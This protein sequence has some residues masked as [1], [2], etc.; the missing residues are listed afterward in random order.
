MARIAYYR[1]WRPQNFD[2]VVAQEQV[3]FP[4][5]QS[6]VKG[7]VGHAYLFTGTR[8]TGKT[9]LA[10]IYAKAVNC[11]DI[12]NGNPCN[13]CA[14]C[15]AINDG[16]L[17]DVVE[18]DA[19]SHNSVDNIRRMADEVLFAPVTARYKVYIIDEAHMLSGG[20]FNALLKTLEEPPAHAIFIL[21][22]TEPH[23]IP[24][25]IISRCQRYDFRRIPLDEVTERLRLIADNYQIDVTDDAL[26][27]MAH[28][29]EGTLRDAI[30]LLD[31]ASTGIEGQ[32]TRDALLDL[33]G[34]MDDEFM[35][36]LAEAL[37]LKRVDRLLPLI[38][39]LMMSGRD[40]VQ[41]VI[42][43]ARY[44]R[45]V[46]ICQITSRPEEMIQVT[47]RTMRD[48]RRLAGLIDRKS[49]ITLIQG[50]SALLGELRWSP[51]LRMSLEIG[52]MRLMGEIPQTTCAEDPLTVD[53]GVPITSG[54]SEPD[55]SEIE[56]AQTVPEPE[57][58][59]SVIDPETVSAKGETPGTVDEDP[60]MPVA[61]DSVEFAPTPSEEPIPSPRE[62]PDREQTVPATNGEAHA[63]DPVDDSVDEDSA[64]DLIAEDPAEDL[65][66]EDPA[67]DPIV[68]EGVMEHDQLINS[69]QHILDQLIELGHIDILIMAR[70][71]H[72]SY[73]GTNW[74]LSFDSSMQSQY[75][76]CSM[77]DAVRILSRLV[78]E[79]MKQPVTIITRINNDNTAKTGA[80]AEPEWLSRI[81]K[82]CRE[83]DVPL[84]VEE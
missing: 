74:Y 76:R 51:D 13:Q 33:V 14:I 67:E 15:N 61:K 20:A 43:I 69:W 9:S 34:L 16:S 46:L 32:I 84:E 65:I 26:R 49:L 1:E 66:A 54:V 71:S 79:E 53:E 18:M 31:Q 5:R 80:T 22:T 4:L 23:R 37:L 30:S 50:L 17:L 52:L 58:I 63:Y 29:A 19:A 21:A 62:E 28:L 42:D 75:E 36:E 68:R 3:V 72:V 45:N 82:V 64:E 40:L 70:S 8:G 77:P 55:I 59:P 39:Q 11:L 48:L 60:A 7:E 35:A 2:E 41:S 10:R 38:S 57:E 12:R 6:I 25:T 44:L 81:R 27:T 56:P 78:S 24:A 73:D 83:T 47:G